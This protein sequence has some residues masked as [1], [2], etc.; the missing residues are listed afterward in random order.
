MA[1][2]VKMCDMSAKIA[3]EVFRALN[4]GKVILSVA[5]DIDKVTGIKTLLEPKDLTY[6]EGWYYSK[7]Y[8]TNKHNSTT[9]QY[10]QILMFNF[11]TN[12]VWDVPY[13]TAD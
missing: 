5:H 10:S 1:K 11:F 12:E 4:P 7:G 9:G 6:P 13:C 8:F 2:T 3:G